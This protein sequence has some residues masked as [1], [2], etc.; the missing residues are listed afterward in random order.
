MMATPG[1]SYFPARGGL[2]FTQ[3]DPVQQLR[4]AAEAVNR[5]NQGQSNCS[6]LLTLNP[7]AISTT[8]TDSRISAQMHVG[9]MPRTADAAAALSAGIYAECSNGT[10]IVHHASNAS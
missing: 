8:I 10:A 4:Q 9:F 5:L 6:A 3:G 1:L 7:S 2:N